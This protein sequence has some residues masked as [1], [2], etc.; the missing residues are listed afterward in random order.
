MLGQER[1]ED[2][3]MLCR[4]CHRRAHPGKR[5]WIPIRQRKGS[6]FGTLTRLLMWVVFLDL[7][8]HMSGLVR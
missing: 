3:R 1:A 5:D 8:A 4:A 2:V 7:F 6:L